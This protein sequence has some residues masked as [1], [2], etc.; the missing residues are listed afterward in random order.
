MSDSPKLVE[1][2]AGRGGPDQNSQ[3]PPLLAIDRPGPPNV[4][5]SNQAAI[6]GHLEL[7]CC[8]SSIQS[9]PRETSNAKFLLDTRQIVTASRSDPDLLLAAGC[10]NRD[11]DDVDLDRMYVE[12]MVEDYRAALSSLL[13]QLSIAKMDPQM[14]C[15]RWNN[16]RNNL[17]TVLDHLL[18][19]EAFC[20]VTLA[21]DNTSIKCHKMILS[22]CS[23][24]FQT[25]FMENSCEHP[26]V[27]LKDIKYG[28]IRAILDYMYKG[29]VNVAQEELPGL[30]KVAELLRVKGLVE[31]EREKLLNTNLGRE[32]GRPSSDQEHYR[33]SSSSAKVNGEHVDRRSSGAAANNASSSSDRE[34]ERER[35]RSNDSKDSPSSGPSSMVRPFM[36][37]PPPGAHPFP[38][39]PLPGIFPGAHNLFGAAGNNREAPREQSGQREDRDRGDSSN[40]REG[41]PSPQAGA[42]RKKVASGSGGSSSS[43]ES[44]LGSLSVNREE[45]PVPMDV[46]RGDDKGHHGDMDKEGMM[47]LPG[48]DKSG[49]AN[50]VP[51]QRLEWKRYKQYTRNDIMS[52]IEEVK[53]GMSALQASRKYG[54]PSRTL[55]DK[56]KKMGITTGRQVQRKSLPQYPSS[57]PG[58][59]GMLNMPDSYK[60]MDDRDDSNDNSLGAPG[61]AMDGRATMVPPSGF[62]TLQMLNIMKE[63]KESE[64]SGGINMNVKGGESEISLRPMNLSTMLSNAS[65]DLSIHKRHSDSSLSP[66]SPAG[67][68]HN[69]ER[70]L[71]DDNSS[72]HHAAADDRDDMVDSSGVRPR[73]SS[74]GSNDGASSVDIRAQFMADLRR[75]GRNIP[76]Q[77]TSSTGNGDLQATSTTT[78]PPP[79]LPPPPKEESLPPRKRKVSQEHHRQQQQQQEYNGIHDEAPPNTDTLGGGGPGSPPAPPVGGKDNNS[80]PSPALECRN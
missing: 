28:E 61:D 15:L 39:F 71:D 10:A 55:Y 7:T 43:K 80:S 16:H 54:V 13:P 1:E 44:G 24:Y 68:P 22:A 33:S 45:Q 17:L 6:P 57:F 41:S 62:S 30:L 60:D 21:C 18:Q 19:T 56:V 34:R 63:M 8:S 23:S 14:F 46:G 25:L 5:I 52:A 20:D 69:N 35:D 27:F 49:I 75:L 47:G 29:E 76:T 58:P 79:H 4:V 9:S 66:R 36:Y 67:G 42:K 38:M 32:G 70:D 12:A 65:R 53:N 64:R 48:L 74:G 37:T 77:S 51:S 40:E 2:M 31:E 78:S 50:Y 73:H 11:I 59:L 26:I 72:R 3:P